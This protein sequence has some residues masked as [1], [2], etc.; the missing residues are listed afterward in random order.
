MV[1]SDEHGAYAVIMM[2]N[3]EVGFS[4][5]QLPFDAQ[6]WLARLHEIVLNQ[7]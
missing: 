5:A 2:F 6:S 1:E 3:D 4:M 7:R